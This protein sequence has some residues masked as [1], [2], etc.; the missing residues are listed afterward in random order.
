MISELEKENENKS[1]QHKADKL[2]DA[3]GGG[4][5]RVCTQLFNQQPTASVAQK[6][7]KQHISCFS[8]MPIKQPGQEKEQKK[9]SQNIEVS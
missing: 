9:L 6:I 4:I 8:P 7:K 3:N 1:N 5:E 2:A